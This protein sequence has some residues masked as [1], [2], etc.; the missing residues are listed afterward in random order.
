MLLN[1]RACGDFMMASVNNN[2]GQ[3][4]SRVALDE[5]RYVA[6]DN[7]LNGDRLKPL[8]TFVS[9]LLTDMYQVITLTLCMVLYPHAQYRSPWHTHCG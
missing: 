1:T 4:L 8:S 6:K 5:S 3:I 9:P 7:G 2:V